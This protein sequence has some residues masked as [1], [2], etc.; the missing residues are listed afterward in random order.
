[1]FNNGKTLIII[2]FLMIT[3]PIFISACSITISPPDCSDKRTKDLVIQIFKENNSVY[4]LSDKKSILSIYM[5]NTR[6]TE[7]DEKIKKYSC[8]GDIVLDSIKGGF[9]SKEDGYSTGYDKLRCKLS[10]TSQFSDKS[11]HYVEAII[12]EYWFS[13]ECEV[14]HIS[15]SYPIQYNEQQNNQKNLVP[16]KN[17]TT[18]NKM[19]DKTEFVD[20]EKD[21]KEI[22][23][24]EELIFN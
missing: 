17:K 11:N 13:P 9:L 5:E 7:Y 12:P 2:S 15:K 21:K 6:P 8:N 22:K 16:E 10:Y 1:M 18:Y 14:H 24:T 4:L 20:S 19:I 3:I 23:K